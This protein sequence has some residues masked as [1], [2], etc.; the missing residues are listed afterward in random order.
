MRLLG[1]GYKQYKNNPDDLTVGE[2]VLYCGHSSST[3]RIFE[4]VGIW[5]NEAIL[6]GR[7][8]E[9]WTDIHINYTLRNV[10]KNGEL[11]K[12]EVQVS[13]RKLKCLPIIFR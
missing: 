1:T 6:R 2:K 13:A 11:G 10:K 3:D 8:V 4:V 12:K 9:G 5:D 7:G